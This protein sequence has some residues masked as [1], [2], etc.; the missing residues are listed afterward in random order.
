[1][2]A[3]EAEEETVALRWDFLPIFALQ[4]LRVMW[5][6]IAFV[7]AIGCL[8]YGVIM[9]QSDR[10]IRAALA[11]SFGIGLASTFGVVLN[12]Y[13]GV[14]PLFCVRDGA[15]AMDAVD[16]AVAFSERHW[17]RLLAL[18]LGFFLLRLLWAATMTLVLLSPLSLS[19]LI[20]GRWIALLMGLV[21]LI[22]F[23]GSDFLRLVR[24]AA[25]VS[26][27]EEDSHPQYSQSAPDL[28]PPT[29]ALPLAGLA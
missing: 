14:A 19:G 1:M 26:L 16:R 20:G 25:Y 9:A 10:P 5:S 27:A 2:F 12:W 6:S 3:P 18:S 28:A 29:D 21:V 13:L 15:G 17:G 11:L 7:V 4:L 23:A 8:F 24:L 22:Y